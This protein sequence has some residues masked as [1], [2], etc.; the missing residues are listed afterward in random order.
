MA[1]NLALDDKR[2]EEAVNVAPI[3]L[4]TNWNPEAKP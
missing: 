1:T 4:V 3:T 2:L